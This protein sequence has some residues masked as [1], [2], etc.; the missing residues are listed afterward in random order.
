MLTYAELSLATAS[1]T[2]EKCGGS[3]DREWEGGRER[4]RE[5]EREETQEISHGE[6]E[7][8]T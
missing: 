7:V 6:R 8:A 1:G 4:E 3:R 2:L 5:R